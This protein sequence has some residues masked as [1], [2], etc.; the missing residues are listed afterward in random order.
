MLLSFLLARYP[1]S[2]YKHAE[3]VANKVKHLGNDY[4]VLALLH[5]ILEDSTVGILAIDREYREDLL[6]L[7]RNK[8]ETYFEYI[9]RVKKGSK[10][11]RIVKLADLEDHL[12]QKSTLKDSLKKRYLKAKEMLN[13]TIPNHT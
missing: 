10:R 9:E 2:T 7:T 5:D 4:R 12:E 1:D 8:N 6:T 13:E 3:R 11:A